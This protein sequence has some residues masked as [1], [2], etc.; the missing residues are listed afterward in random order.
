[1]QQIT[2]IEVELLIPLNADVDNDG[3]EVGTAFIAFNQD[4]VTSDFWNVLGETQV[5]GIDPAGNAV[6][7]VA[8]NTIYLGSHGSISFATDV[9]NPSSAAVRLVIQENGRIDIGSSDTTG[10][11]LVL[12]TKT[13]SGDPT[14]VNGGMYYNSNLGKFR[15]YE[16]GEWVNCISAPPSRVV[17]TSSGTFTKAS[18]PGLKGIRVQCQGGGGGSAG[19]AATGAGQSSA[20]GGG[21]GGGYAEVYVPA[22]SLASSVTVTVGA[23]GSGG[24]AGAN[25]GTAGGTTSFGS[26]CSA[27]GGSPGEAEPASS[28]NSIPASGNGGVGTAGDILLRGGDGQDPV[29][30]GGN[31]GALGN[32]GTSYFAPG[33]RGANASDAGADGVVGYNY[34]GGAAGAHN[35]P[36]QVTA[37]A[38]ADGA[39]GIVVVTLY[40]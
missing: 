29:I 8:A 9:N 12:D 34:G 25:D 30:S 5:A 11:L 26:H 28:G 32:G 23:G 17:F 14:G 24:A 15:C 37:R 31:R 6:A 36:S 19:A 35:G 33:M 27:T 3:G 1:M 38:G 18:Y 20:G 10:A 4:G 13:N 21:G 40:F 39:P 7:G 22:S 2:P 16:N